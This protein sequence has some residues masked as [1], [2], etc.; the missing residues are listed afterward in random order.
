MKP[1]LLKVYGT[2]RSESGIQL[3]RAQVTLQVVKV[4][5]L[6]KLR[7][8]KVYRLLRHKLRAL[9]LLLLPL[10]PHLYNLQDQLL[11]SL[12]DLRARWLP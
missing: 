4:L 9:R 11:I 2:V 1:T 6:Q 5:Y 8:L 3:A 12:K 7:C 10:L